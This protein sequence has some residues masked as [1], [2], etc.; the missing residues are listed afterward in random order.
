MG[1]L[2]PTGLG[3][4]EFNQVKSQ[5]VVIT[6]GNQITGTLCKGSFKEFDEMRLQITVYWNCP[7]KEGKEEDVA[8][9]DDSE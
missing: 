9:V 4:Y 7:Q 8:A 6:C 2:E 1:D 3:E 5:K